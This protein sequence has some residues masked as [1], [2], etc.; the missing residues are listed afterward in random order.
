M[1]A[2][3][4]LTIL[5]L[6]LF[7]PAI[8]IASMTVFDKQRYSFFIFAVAVFSVIPVFLS[9]EKKDS[10]VKKLVMIAVMTSLSV[11]SRI[12]FEWVPHFKPVTAIVIITGICLG[13]EAGFLCGAFSALISNFVFG[14]GPWTPFQMMTWGLIGVFSAVLGNFLKKNLALC[15][16][17]GALSGVFYSFLMDV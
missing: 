17:F 3:K 12:I 9:L 7:I 5:I 2:K 11:V 16:I 6:A 1:K 13:K 10:N 15:C 4:I 8:V 14:Q